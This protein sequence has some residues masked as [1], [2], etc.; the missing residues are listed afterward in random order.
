MVFIYDKLSFN[1][2]TELILGVCS[3]I[4]ISEKLSQ[5]GMY[6]VRRKYQG[7]GIGKA[8]WMQIMK[9]CENRSICLFSV[10]QMIHKYEKIGFNMRYNAIVHISRGKP[11]LSSLVKNIDGI[12]IREMNEQDLHKVCEYDLKVSQIER[13]KFLSLFLNERETIAF[14]AIKSN[15]G[16]AEE[17]VG[18]GAIKK[19]NL[20]YA[21]LQ[22]IYANNE[23]IAELIVRNCCQKFP[24][25][26][27]GILMSSWDNNCDA[28][29][30][31]EKLG[32]EFKSAEPLLYTKQLTTGDTSRIYSLL[33]TTF[34]TS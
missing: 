3:G 21:L 1:S 2:L 11:D 22:P 31:I 14:L 28:I 20:N 12:T 33:T 29:H 13:S 7:L 34:Y 8:I 10:H 18:F 5:I 17:V 19:S 26:V 4:N 32:L 25:A 30:L 24:Q 27:N 15:K 16:E 23:E 6:A 9:H